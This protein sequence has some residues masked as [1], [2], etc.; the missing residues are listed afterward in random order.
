MKPELNV[1]PPTLL[2][3]LSKHCGWRRVCN[4]CGKG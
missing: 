3:N 2:E 1:K 4:N